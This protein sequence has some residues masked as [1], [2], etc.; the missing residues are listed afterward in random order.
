MAGKRADV[1][2]H[3]M[4]LIDQYTLGR[5]FEVLTATVAVHDDLWAATPDQRHHCRTIEPARRLAEQDQ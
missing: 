3:W 4:M 1:L 5:A 2:R